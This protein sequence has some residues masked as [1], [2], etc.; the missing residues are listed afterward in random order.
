[1]ISD[2]ESTLLKR[3]QMEYLIFATSSWGYYTEHCD[4]WGVAG[5]E[6]T[7]SL[8]WIEP[9]LESRDNGG[10]EEGQRSRGSNLG[11]NISLPLVLTARK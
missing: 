1:M 7:L 3:S 10:T 5:P 2:H 4:Y 11:N 6:Q 8:G 9:H